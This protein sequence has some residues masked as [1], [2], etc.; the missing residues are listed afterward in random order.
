MSI[1]SKLTELSLTLPPA[2]PAGGIYHFVVVVDKLMYVSG[3]GPVRQDGSLITGKLGS[4]LQTEEGFLAARQEA[5]TMYP[6]KQLRIAADL[7]LSQRLRQLDG[8]CFIFKVVGQ[9]FVNA[10]DGVCG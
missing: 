3:Q 6:P 9:E 4:D 7:F 1:E 10:V 5:L 8:G 2:P